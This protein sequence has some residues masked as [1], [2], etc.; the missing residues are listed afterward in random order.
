MIN[1]ETTLLCGQSFAWRQEGDTYS[2]VVANRVIT[3]TEKTFVHAVASDQTLSHYFDCAWHYDEAEEYLASIDPHLA[4]CIAQHRSIRILN[5]DPWETTISF[6]LSQNNNIARITQLHRALCQRWGSEVAEGFYAFP[7]AEQLRC[8]TEG[9]LR[10]LGVGY[11]SSY[12]LDAVANHELLQRVWELDDLKASHLLQ[13]IKGVGAK[14][15]ACI[16]L[17][18]YHRMNVVPVDTWIE[19]VQLNHPH[20]TSW[21]LFSPYAGLAQ[22]YL[23][24]HERTQGGAV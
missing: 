24:H 22:Q 15:A 7:T 1:L 16:L 13:T 14:V 19:R 5:Q 23:F 18:A 10:S 6:I 12:V 4:A 11:R 3:L 17:F 9:E 20:Y 21:D 2:A 8:A